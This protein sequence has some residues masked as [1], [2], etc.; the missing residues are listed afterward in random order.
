[1]YRFG[2]DITPRRTTEI[3]KAVHVELKAE[4]RQVD[5]AKK[6][7]K[8]QINSTTDRPL[9][10]SRFNDKEKLKIHSTESHLVVM[11]YSIS[12][13]Y[14]LVSLVRYNEDVILSGHKTSS[15]RDTRNM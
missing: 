12:N 11:V 15:H 4:T 3:C 5:G 13:N 2:V 6:Q 14:I 7:N 9:I 8:P 10:P 1:M